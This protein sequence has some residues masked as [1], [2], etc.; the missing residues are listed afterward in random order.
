MSQTQL[1]NHS[2]AASLQQE[3]PVPGHAHLMLRVY[4]PVKA[5]RLSE[6]LSQ[7]F[8]VLKHG[9]PTARR[10]LEPAERA[11]AEQLLKNQFPDHA[12]LL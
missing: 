8:T 2:P 1:A 3:V 12:K 6:T 9:E 10:E 4:G 7:G 11:S 5:S